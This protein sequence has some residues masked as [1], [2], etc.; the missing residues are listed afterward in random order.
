[1]PETTQPSYD[2]LPY[3]YDREYAFIHL[4]EK[5]VERSRND[6]FIHYPTANGFK[7]LTYGDIDHIATNLAC[8]WAQETQGV[9]IIGFL[10]DTS[11][12]YLVSML[13]FLKLRI[14]FMSL[15]PRNSQPAL[16]N[17]MQKTGAKR[18]FATAK[19]SE[20]ARSTTETVGDCSCFILPSFDFDSLLSEPRHSDADSLRN[21]RFDASDIEKIALIIHTY[22]YF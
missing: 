11:V 1:M 15:S 4:F 17:L 19:Y 7:T 3:Q 10:A 14:T 2:Q 16:V 20:V 13:A 12:F 8:Q 6:P 21:R 5:F 22:V 9:D 18:L